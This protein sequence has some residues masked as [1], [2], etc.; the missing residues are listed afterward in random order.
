LPDGL[1]SNQKSLFGKIFEGL[2]LE[3]VDM[4]Y[5]HSEYFTDIWDIS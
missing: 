3:K 1:F 4:V 5:E 2:G